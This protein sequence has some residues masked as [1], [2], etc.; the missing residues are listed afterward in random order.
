M[1]IYYCFIAIIIS[2]GIG[3]I[4]MKSSIY[5]PTNLRHLVHLAFT[6]DDLYKPIIEDSFT[7]NKDGEHKTYNLQAKYF[8]YYDLSLLFQNDGI[9]SNY[10]F[11]GILLV[12]FLHKDIVVSSMIADRIITAGY[13]GNNSSKYKKLTLLTFEIPVIKKYVNNISL[14][15]TFLKIDP[16]LIEHKDV[17]LSIAVST[18]P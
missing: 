6:P 13:A 7:F 18:T 17:K 5:L 12:E 1:K 9:S 8:D 15:L 14:R 2:I 10:K 4:V 11:T 3:F 16:H